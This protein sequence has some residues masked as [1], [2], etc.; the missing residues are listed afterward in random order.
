MNT[1]FGRVDVFDAHIH[2]FSHRFFE[3]LASQSASLREA[4]DPVGAIAERAGLVVP[5]ADPVALAD[6]WARELDR[7]AVDRAML[8]ASLP[9]DEESV[10]QAIRAFPRRFSGAFMLDPTPAESEQRVRRAIGDLGLRMLCLFPAMH[11]YPVAATESVR[12]VLDRVAETPG[13]AVFVHCGVLSVGLRKKLALPS[14][15]DMRFS[16]PLDIHPLAL[17]Y[18]AVPFV[19][20]HFGAG[21]LREALMLAD[22]CPNVFLDTSSTNS[23]TRYDVPKPS[24]REVF[25]RALEVAGPSRLLFGTDS[26]FFPRGWN[27]GVFERQLEALADLRIAPEHA[28]AIFGGNLRAILGISKDEPAGSS[29]ADGPALTEGAPEDT[30]DG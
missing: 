22:L 5:P 4:P 9:G 16:N 19:V 2:F 24:L 7:Y 13:C 18:P 30:R 20:P 26:S 6:V 29:R 1:P 10:S 3:L 21:M 8:I 23:W 27:S 25:E 11:R 12:R 28:R 15:F 14:R 17:D